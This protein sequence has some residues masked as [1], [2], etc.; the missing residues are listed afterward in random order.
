MTLEQLKDHI[1]TI[2]IGHRAIQAFNFGEEF[3]IDD[4]EQG[5]VQQVFLEIPYTVNYDITGNKFKTF[6][7]AL[8]VLFP[9]VGEDGVVL[10]HISISRAESIGDAIITKFQDTIRAEGAIIADVNAISLRNISGSDLCGIRFE[11]T[12]RTFRTFCNKNYT[13][14]FTT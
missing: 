4:I 2:S 5:R 9:S 3:I 11:L 12:I 8:L 14:E 10:D 6:Q 1:E 7:F 13:D